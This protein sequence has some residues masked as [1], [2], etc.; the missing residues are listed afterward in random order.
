LD[1][2]HYENKAIRAHQEGIKVSC[3]GELRK[4]KNF[5]SL[6]NPLNFHLLQDNQTHSSNLLKA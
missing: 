6:L 4:K 5:F 1:K 2:V 3:H